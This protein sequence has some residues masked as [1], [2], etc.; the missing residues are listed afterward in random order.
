MTR[1]VM[2]QYIEEE[3]QYLLN[4]LRNEENIKKIKPLVQL[5]TIYIC[6]HGSSYNA[7]TSISGFI[8]EMAHVRVYTYTPSN[9]KHNAKSIDF[10]NKDKTLV[11]GI[12]ETGTSRGVLEAL[13]SVKDK[14]FKIL[15]LTNEKNSPI[16]TLSNYTLYLECNEENSNAKTKGY[17]CTLLLLI[18][19]GLYLGFAKGYIKKEKLQYYL[20]ELQDEVENLE[21]LFDSFVS[22]C[23]DA[24]YGKNMKNIYVV[25]D[26]MQFGSSL[27]G[28]LKLM[29]TMCIPT[30]FN[31]IGEFSHGMHRSLN[32]N[33]HVLLLDDGTEKELV[34]KTHQYLKKKGIDVLL[35]TTQRYAYDDTI[36]PIQEFKT[37]HSVLS[38][39]YLIQ[40][41]SVF[42]PELNG[43]DPNRYANN[44]YTEFVDTRVE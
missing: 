8:S 10:E 14:D 23:K 42:V 27:E 35:L 16:D 26:G 5:E 1:S 43:L 19:I 39:I 25:G 12:S 18:L 33:S 17:S 3:P 37:D 6:A 9:F 2:W 7:A 21:S 30:M 31:D 34:Y 32:Q 36:Y 13:E 44:D 4:I 15:A 11:L 28:Q 20:K 24:N 38:M 41:V 40:I 29:E 22:W